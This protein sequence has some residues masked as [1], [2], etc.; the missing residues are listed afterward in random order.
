MT[1]P[2]ATPSLDQ[3]ALNAFYLLCRTYGGIETFNEA[4]NT[5]FSDDYFNNYV[6]NDM[7]LNFPALVE[8]P[9]AMVYAGPV[10][11]GIVRTDQDKI[12]TG[13]YYNYTYTEFK[14]IGLLS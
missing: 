14:K 9:A 2:A 8:K 12:S 7:V 1:Q 3:N 4:W 6:K 13:T 5:F 11:P 10:R